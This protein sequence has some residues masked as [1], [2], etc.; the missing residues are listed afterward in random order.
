[1]KDS[2]T[3]FLRVEFQAND[4]NKRTI[5][6][7]LG[8]IKPENIANFTSALVTAFEILHKVRRHTH[9]L[10]KKN[11][12]QFSTS[13]LSRGFY[14]M[15]SLHFRWFLT[16]RKSYLNYIAAYKCIFWYRCRFKHL[17]FIVNFNYNCLLDE[18]SFLPNTFSFRNSLWCRLHFMIFECFL[19]V[20]QPYWARMSVQSSHHAYNRWPSSKLQRGLQN[21][22]LASHAS[23]NVF[24]SGRS[25]FKR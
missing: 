11:S 14:G 2:V 12:I 24:I 23:Q 18:W 21:V 1:M 17:R 8:T 20:V 13:N 5:K 16:I 22:Q 10:C 9:L 3:L 15:Q 7:A 25:R 4:E 19:F 6:D